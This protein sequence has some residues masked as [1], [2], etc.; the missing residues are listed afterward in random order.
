[1]WVG[2]LAPSS[3]RLRSPDHSKG[4]TCYDLLPSVIKVMLS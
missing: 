1:M 3:M 4:E 2:A